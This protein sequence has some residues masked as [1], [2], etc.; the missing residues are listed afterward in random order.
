[1]IRTILMHVVNREKL[2]VVLTATFTLG[3][4]TAVMLKHLKT[5]TLTSALRMRH[6][7]LPVILLQPI[8]VTLK[9]THLTVTGITV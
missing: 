6:K 2:H 4:T 8:M 7:P 9:R 5:Q 3:P 1:M